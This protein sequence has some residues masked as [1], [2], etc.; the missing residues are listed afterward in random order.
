MGKIKSFIGETLIYG[1]GNIFSRIFTLFLIPLYAE[2]LGKID[3]SN[4]IMLQS[5]FTIIAFLLV[6]NAGV[7][8]YYYEYEN[9]K[10][11]RIVFT[12]WFYYQ[13]IVS[14][15]LIIIL[16]LSSPYLSGFFVIENNNESTIQ[17]GLILI[18]FQL[19]PLIFN[20][21]NMNYFRIDRQPKKVVWIVTLE[22]AFTI[23]FVSISLMVLKLGLISVLVSQII[24][25][26]LVA[27]LYTK[28][29]K[30]YINIKYFSKKLLKKII[31]YSWPFFISSIFSWTIISIDKF[32]GAQELTDKTEVA[33]L[34]LAMQLVLPITI[35]S[36]MIRMAVGP[37]VMS[38]RKEQ[39][40]EESYQKIFELIIFASS[41]VMISLT[42]ISP[43]LAVILT[44]ST[45]IGVIYVIPLMALAKVFS[46]A[47][48]QFSI[49]FNL[50]KKNVYI[51]YSVMLAGLIGIAINYI[52]MGEYGFIVSGFSQIGSYLLMAIFLFFTG[53]KV[54][55]LRIKL[56]RSSYII[57]AVIVYTLLLYF[58]NPLVE[59]GEYLIFILT[60]L[61]FILLVASIYFIQQ[62]MNPFFILK[63]IVSKA[64]RITK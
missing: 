29:N 12:S 3:Y 36:D 23:T 43:L 28:Y 20:S 26:F 40:A 32:I 46:L 19:I 61:A 59:N 16:I 41:F 17:W 48:N 34:A 37:Y 47:A 7:F 27:L 10:Y 14:I 5:T 39:D 64:L 54:A 45:Y 55:K 13:L 18:G 21:T 30:L 49:S 15:A 31:A 11:K 8:F 51:M 63:M 44:D 53:R 38:I 4:L 52:F 22:A 9:F 24:A 33:L 2:F 35:L 60:S 25:R 50:Q 42:L 57:F 62:K 6:L 58:I 1:F 56:S